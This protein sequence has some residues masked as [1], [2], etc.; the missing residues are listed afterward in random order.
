MGLSNTPGNK[1]N[2]Y[3]P[4]YVVFDLETTGIHP[5]FDQ[6]VEISAIKVTGGFVDSEFSMLVNP[7]MH[8]PY[9]A[10]AVNHITDSMVADSPTFD[11]AFQEFLDFIGDSVLVGH[12]IQLF[13]LKFL[14]RDAKKF[15]GKNLGND[16]VDTLP[17]SRK[18]LPEL[19]HHTL[20]DL[21]KHYNITIKDAHRALGDCRMNQRI[22]ESLREDMEN[23][24]DGA[25]AVLTCPKCGNVLRKKNGKFGPF[26][27]CAGYPD[28]RYTRNI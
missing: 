23:P 25:K 21:A 22:Y 9:N 8:I 12:N 3:V 14:Y 13:D 4:D 24:S 15:W 28:C 20:L 19:K 6:V 11:V 26:Y 2:N 18:Y 1:L 5:S 27:G 7:L 16:Y 10:S 17:L